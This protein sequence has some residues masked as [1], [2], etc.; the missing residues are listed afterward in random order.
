MREA[1]RTAE[2]PGQSGFLAACPGGAELEAVRRIAEEI[3]RELSL[4]RLLRLIT[5]HARL[6]TRAE[7]C[8][9]RL[10]NPTDECFD[11]AVW[12]G[13]P[14]VHSE[15]PLRLFE[16]VIGEAARA[17]TGR[18]VN[19]YPRH[20]GALADAAGA[21]AVSAGLAVPLLYRD[22]LVGVI[23]VNHH[24]PGR[25]FGEA[26]LALLGLLSS[27]T[28]IA[29]ENARLYQEAER[30]RQEAEVAADLSRRIGASLDL[31]TVLQ[32]VVE[33]ARQLTG[34]DLGEIALRDAPEGP[35]HFRYQAG[36]YV[37]GAVRHQIEPGKGVGGRVLVTGLP[38]RTDDYAADARIS[39]EYLTTTLAEKV[40]AELAVPIRIEERVEGVI[41]VDNRAPRPF[42]A[43]DERTLV[44]LAEHAAIAIRNAR[45]HA[46]ALWRAQQFAFLNAVTQTLASN[47]DPPRVAEEILREIRLLIP[48]TAARLW[49][50]GPDGATLVRLA[51]AGLRDPDRWWR[52]TF[53]M[54]E[55]LLGLAI[56]TGEPVTSRDTA[57]D[58]RVA[59]RV[60]AG[61]EGLVSTIVLP[62]AAGG[63][64]QGALAVSTR[65]PHE[66]LPEEI[67]LLG[68]FAVQAGIALQNARLFAEVQSGQ[69]EL[70]HLTRRIVT[71]Q[72]E[73]R[74]RLS[75]E[76]HDETGQALSALR[77]GL[78][79]VRQEL[80]AGMAGPRRRLEEA[81]ALTQ[82]TMDQ[83]RGLAQALRPPA[84][85]TLGLSAAL[86][87]F[88]RSFAVQT[89][90]EVAY[91]G[92]EIGSLPDPISIHL[93]RCLQEALNNVVKHARARRVRVTLAHDGAQIRLTVEDDGA[94]FE[95]GAV[96][97][98]FPS[99]GLGLRGMRERLDSLHGRLEIISRPGRGVRLVA[100]VPWKEQA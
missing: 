13:R 97:G 5:D 23:A 88:C 60:W 10:W 52:M 66:F 95:P 17:R 3:T 92:A 76:L 19:D 18:I 2:P 71:A 75:R 38:F 85:D 58:P 56:A 94:G 22:R 68:S 33:A 64:L 30:Q 41:F 59:N 21:P 46:A 14:S 1:E 80:P 79:L 44:R 48:E 28:A 34:A 15:R 39:K 98:P 65:M 90:L 47:L 37:S 55:G 24:T 54:R 45:M 67:S 12:S 72:E 29:I 27:Q 82:T 16:G 8:V 51:C 96:P 6:L 91:E 86:E 69:R 89:R 32:L 61:S 77:I 83:I 78:D 73:E 87:G 53:D 50:I 36:A 43:A 40:V 20:P 25:R 26:D 4:P 62:L 7:G 35:L 42:A 81:I 100:A 70:L 9:I 11:P 93:Y 99:E 31:D 84:L 57:A 63:R 74:R 49:E